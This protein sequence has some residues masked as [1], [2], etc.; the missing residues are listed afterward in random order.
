MQ[1]MC[2]MRRPRKRASPRACYLINDQRSWYTLRCSWIEQLR[3]PLQQAAADI[4]CP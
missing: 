1:G 3:R 2:H 4:N